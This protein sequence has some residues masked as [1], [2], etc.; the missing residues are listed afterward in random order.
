MLRWYIV[1]DTW[2]ETQLTWHNTPKDFNL[3]HNCCGNFK[4]HI[5]PLIPANANLMPQANIRLD[6]PAPKYSGHGHHLYPIM[7]LYGHMVLIFSNSSHREFIMKAG[8][9]RGIKISWVMWWITR[10]IISKSTSM[11]K[12]LKMKDDKVVVENE[13]KGAVFPTEFKSSV[14]VQSGSSGKQS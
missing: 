2:K 11:S 8:T 13:E 6:W 14:S 5:F 10:I 3:P 7:H 4:S 1:T 12:Y 9:S